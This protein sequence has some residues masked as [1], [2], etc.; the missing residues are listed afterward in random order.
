MTVDKDT[1]T[2]K[3]EQ[4]IGK[5]AEKLKKKFSDSERASSRRTDVSK[6]IYK[7]KISTV[8]ACD[9]VGVLAITPHYGR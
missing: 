8:Q 3:Y 6:M 2:A 7:L 4:L 5:H 9:L 1:N